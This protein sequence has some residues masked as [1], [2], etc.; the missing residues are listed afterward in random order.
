MKILLI[1]GTGI[2]STAVSRKIAQAGHELWLINRGNDADRV[3]EGAH[4][5]TADIGQTGTVIQAL[6]GLFFDC[7][8][9]F[10]VQKPEQIDRDHR[11]FRGKTKQYIFISS[12]CVY[13]RPLPH[14]IL[15]E[16][17]PVYNP[18]WDYAQNKIACENRLMEIYR[19]GDLPVTIIRP[20]HTYDDRW[21]P[22]CVTGSHGGYCIVKRML[23]GKPVIIPGDGTS[24]WTLTHNSDFAEAF[25]GLAGNPY[26][27]GETVN[28][29]SDEVMTWNQ[30]YQTIADTLG[31]PLKPFYVSSLFLH[32]AGPYDLKSCLIGERV[33]SAV[34]HNDKLKR[35][36]PGFQ[37]H[38][39]FREGIRETLKHIMEDT[40]L[41]DEDPV[42]D[43][44]SDSLITVLTHAAKEL[45]DA[46]PSAL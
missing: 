39:P 2:I 8:A 38:V 29:S 15:T 11:L 7:V 23:A 40:R 30:I 35:L 25:L 28:I 36:V 19:S 5:I 45:K 21:L 33:Q 18:Y 32:A 1:G 20:G 6:E 17:S 31:V 9:D 26:A 14:Y 34:F 12:S 27:I 44:W 4:V 22:L 37:A 41:Q 42:F 13:Q 10:T 3:P 46:F 43:A 16:G 24:L